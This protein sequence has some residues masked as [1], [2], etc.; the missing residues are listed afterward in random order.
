MRAAC[1]CVCGG[2]GGTN[3]DTTERNLK[4]I[5]ERSVSFIAPSV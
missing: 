1:V 5:G 4:K 3:R 2:G